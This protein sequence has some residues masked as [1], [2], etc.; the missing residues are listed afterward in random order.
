MRCNMIKGIGVDVVDLSRVEKQILKPAFLKRIFSSRELEIL[1][2][3]K[4][5]IQLAG[6]H[7]AVKEAVS[8]ALGTGISGCDL[9]EIQVL[10]H[11][12]GKPYVK[13]IGDMANKL[14][15]C[16]IHVSISHDGGIAVAYVILEEKNE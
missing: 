6:G 14:E 3:K 16:N 12:N 2:S 11:E 4:N 10:N 8:K 7:F 9:S 15:G 1:S 5:K 13:L